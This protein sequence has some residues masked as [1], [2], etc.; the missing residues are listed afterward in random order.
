MSELFGQQTA[1]NGSPSAPYRVTIARSTRRF[2]SSI[3]TAHTTFPFY[4]LALYLFEC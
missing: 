1:A 2:R 3:G 4:R